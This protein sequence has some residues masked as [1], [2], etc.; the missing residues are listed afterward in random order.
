MLRTPALTNEVGVHTFRTPADYTFGSLQNGDEVRYV[1]NEINNVS[2]KSGTIKSDRKGSTNYTRKSVRI[3]SFNRFDFCWGPGTGYT[4]YKG[5]SSLSQL[6]MDIHAF[7][8]FSSYNVAV[9]PNLRSQAITEAKLKVLDQRVNLAEDLYQLKETY[10]GLVDIYRVIIEGYLSIRKHGSIKPGLRKALGGYGVHLP[11]VAANA[12]LAYFYGI[13]PLIATVQS[14]VGLLSRDVESKVQTV[15]RVVSYDLDSSRLAFQPYNGLVLA[16]PGAGAQSAR[17]T[18]KYRIIGSA[19][20][21]RAELGWTN[22]AAILWA[23]IPYSFVLDWLLPVEDWLRSFS[24]FRG[25]QIVDMYESL[26]I[27]GSCNLRFDPSFYYIGSLTRGPLPSARIR[28]T[29][30]QRSTEVKY[31]LVMTLPFVTERFRLTQS[32]SAL[33]LAA[34]STIY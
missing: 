6:G 3:D 19:S 9:S 23:V 18:I 29:A 2:V 17:C 1:I 7:G 5:E 8:V 33:A 32:I 16:E 28:Y 31:G 12:W 24:A 27:Y 22:P 20:K 4:R 14:L 10:D 30:F 21:L 15:S 25:V 11:R 26:V 13:K 34:K